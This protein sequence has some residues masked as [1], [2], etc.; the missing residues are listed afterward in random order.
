MSDEVALI[1]AIRAALLAEG[2]TPVYDMVAP[3]NQPM[4][5]TVIGSATMPE[6]DTD[7]TLGYNVTV[8]IHTWSRGVDRS[9]VSTM[10]QQIRTALHRDKL[11]L[12]GVVGVQQEFM[13]IYMDNSDGT[14]EVRHGVQRF[15]VFYQ[16]SS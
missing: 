15:R 8:T 11:N 10:Q 5:Y 4:P 12:A 13:D 3:Q 16:P 14:N 2:L 6:D 1:V 7:N 9:Q